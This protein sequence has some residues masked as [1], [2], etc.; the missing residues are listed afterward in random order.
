MGATNCPETPRQR[1]IGMMYLVLTALLALNVSKEILDS[2]LIVNESL[3]VTNENFTK[4]LD[5][6]YSSFEKQY[7]LNKA[8]IEPYW[9]KAQLAKKYSQ[10]LI[11]YIELIRATVISKEEGLTVEECD[12]IN[13][14]NVKA[15]DKYDEGTHYLIGDQQDGSTGEARKLKDKIVEYKKNMISLLDPKYRKTIEEAFGLNVEGPFYD[16]DHTEQN[17]E[18]H[19]FYHTILAANVVILNKM[20]AEVKNA[21]FDVVSQLY[22]EVSIED[23]KFDKIAAKVV[24]KSNYVLTGENFEADIFV[25]AYDTKQTPE[26]WIGSSVDSTTCEISG[27]KMKVEGVDGVGKLSMGA[28]GVGVRTYGGVIKVNTPGGGSK[29]YPFSGEYIVAQPSATISPTKMNVFYIGVDNPVSISVPGVANDQVRVS[30]SGGGGSCTKTGNGTYNVKV[31]TIGTCKITVSAEMGGS[32]RSM[33]GMEFRVK[34]VPDP[35]AYVGGVKTGNISKGVLAASCIIPKME[36]FDFD[37]NFRIVSFS[38]TMNMQGDLI[39]KT[40]SG[41][42]FSGEMKSMLDRAGRGQKIYIEDIKAVGPDGTTRTLSPMNLR[43]N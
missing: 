16:A 18:M 5:G 4:K 7:N 26:I 24:P 35:V 10:E 12:T 25:A 40:T 14:R 8:K 19:N 41:N 31:S 1:M 43:I 32:S 17:W 38:L 15:R 29:S 37:L 36:N 9:K 27:E 22:S 39:T 33:G 23:F 28:G 11:D 2:F 6:S 21:E 13:I 42:C 3:I 20:I 30:I 34:R